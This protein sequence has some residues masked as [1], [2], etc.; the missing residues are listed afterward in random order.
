MQEGGP[1]VEKDK[2]RVR[3]KFFAAPREALGTDEIALN[4][5]AGSTVKDLI[6]TLR[7]E[8]PVL[9]TYTRF[10]STAVNRAYVG[11]QTEL[12]D[13]DEV[14]CLPPVGGG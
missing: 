4:I 6:D 8:Y 2:I 14:A 10:L 3:V 1:S 7:D 11:R 5:P 12:H 13:G 9:E